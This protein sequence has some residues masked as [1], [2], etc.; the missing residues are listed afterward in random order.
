MQSAFSLIVL[1]VLVFF[2]ARLTGT[3]TDLYLPADA[4]LEMREDFAERHGFNDPLIVQFGRFLANIS[5]GDFGDSLRQSRPALT[6]VLEAFPTTLRLAAWTISLSLCISVVIGCVAAIRP[7][8]VFD[9]V[10]TVISLAGA[11]APSFWVAIVAVMFFSVY[12][13]WL[14]TSGTGGFRHWIIPVGV[15]MIRPV[16]L[17]AQVVRGSMIGILSSEYVKTAYA[18]GVR[19]RSI[20]FVHALRNAMLPVITVTG[21]QAVAIING[22]VVIE[23][24]FGFPG[25]GKLMID[26]IVSR[27]FAVI[28]AVVMVAAMAIFLLNVLIDLTYVVLDPRVRYSQ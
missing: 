22:A 11:A 26:A 19:L 18:K 16:G 25:I 27:D 23:M 10:A 4:S 15:L 7:G 24:I 5:H 2:M 8:G 28:Q 14:P 20:V 3:P 9:R 1:I 21:D 12:L 17:I 13:G 6:I